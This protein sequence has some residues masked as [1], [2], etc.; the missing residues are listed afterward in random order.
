MSKQ[1]TPV[2]LIGACVLTAFFCA[3]TYVAWREGSYLALVVMIPLALVFIW[4]V[5]DMLRH[6]T[7]QP[8][9]F[10]RFEEGLFIRLMLLVCSGGVIVLLLYRAGYDGAAILLLLV[11]V[12][13]SLLNARK[14]RGK[15]ETSAGYKQR[16][17]YHESEQQKDTN[18]L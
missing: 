10:G 15:N 12:V 11:V 8:T 4:G 13:S 16:V 1:P 7:R 18:Q 14:L 5:V 3:S 2:E 9:A 17:G 6:G